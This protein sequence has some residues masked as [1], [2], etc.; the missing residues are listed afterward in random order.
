[1]N[2]F[3]AVW[4]KMYG[5]YL[6]SKAVF[7]FQHCVLYKPW[8][9]QSFSYLL[10]KIM[11]YIHSEPLLYTEKDSSKQFGIQGCF[12]I[13]LAII[14]TIRKILA[15]SHVHSLSIM[16]TKG[17]RIQPN[18]ILS[19]AWVIA[20]L[21]LHLLVVLCLCLIHLFLYMSIFL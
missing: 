5:L 20:Y 6:F 11:V 16:L 3:T 2:E 1:M 21:G 10:L 15:F 17:G 14:A 12:L 9:H 7:T 18:I 13:G 4:G 8:L 19:K